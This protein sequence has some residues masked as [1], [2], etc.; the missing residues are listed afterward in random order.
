MSREAIPFSIE[1]KF[2]TPLYKRHKSFCAQYKWREGNT[3]KHT[4]THDC[5]CPQLH[6]EILLN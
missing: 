4:H 6:L 3:H 5:G 1:A 2:K